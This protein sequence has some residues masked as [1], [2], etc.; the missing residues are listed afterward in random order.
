MTVRLA[1][2]NASYLT[3]VCSPNLGAEESSVLIPDETT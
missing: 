1:F 2:H 3:C